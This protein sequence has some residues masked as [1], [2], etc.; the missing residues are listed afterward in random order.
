MGNE[1]THVVRVTLTVEEAAAITRGL[2]AK[3]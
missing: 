3:A 1:Q 2:R